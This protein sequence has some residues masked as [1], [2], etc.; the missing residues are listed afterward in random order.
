V[1][2]GAP[3]ADDLG[4]VARHGDQHGDTYADV[5]A[6][7]P[8]D[9]GGKGEQGERGEATT[10]RMRIATVRAYEPLAGR[11]A[12]KGAGA[13]APRRGDPPTP[14]TRVRPRTQR[15]PW[16]RVQTDVCGRTSAMGSTCRYSA[17]PPPGWCGSHPRCPVLAMI[18]PLPASTASLRPCK[19]P[20]CGPWLTLAI[21]VRVRTWRAPRSGGPSSNS[22][23]AGSLTL[24]L[25]ETRR[26]RY[27][28][29]GPMSCGCQRGVYSEA[30]ALEPTGPT[31][32]EE[33]TIQGHLAARCRSWTG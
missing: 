22:P 28:A 32:R 7:D 26:T 10:S 13:A 8:A 20:T 23:P 4:A 31:M 11:D 6:H 15:V 25:R 30:Q 19:R 18:S 33:G 16:V 9:G 24:S 1:T 3:P 12:H 5:G 29:V 21:R 17:T 14:H 2:P 27:G